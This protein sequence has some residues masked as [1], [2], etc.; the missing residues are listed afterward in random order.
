M[1]VTTIDT[2]HMR[3]ETHYQFMEVFRDVITNFKDVIILIN[4]LLD[5][6]D[7]ILALEKALVDASRKIPLTKQLA[8]ADARIDRC[9]V[10][11][12]STVNAALHHFDPTMVAAAVILEARLKEFGNIGSKSYENESTA[13]QIL[14]RDLLNTFAIQVTKLQLTPWVTELDNSEQAF[15]QLYLE[16]IAEMADLPE[17]KFI[18]VRQDIDAVFHKIIE[19]LEADTVSNGDALCGECIGRINNEIV[20]YKEIIHRVRHDI[21]HAVAVPVPTQQYTGKAIIPIPEVHYVHEGKPTVELVFSV[22]FT[23]TYKENVNVGDAEIIIH[24]KGKYK[25]QKI[26]TF[27]IART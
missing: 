25:G 7:Q 27:N 18:K 5:L 17:V 12:N 21:E 26:V 9:I 20:L 24:G 2:S 10:G 4:A 8:E 23:V 19:A 22:D 6:F 15:H 16:R 3:N 13:V 14:V 1:K 11:I